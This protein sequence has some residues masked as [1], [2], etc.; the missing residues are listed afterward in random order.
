MNTKDALEIPPEVL[1]RVV[2]FHVYNVAPPEEQVLEAPRVKFAVGH[3]FKNCVIV[4]PPVDPTSYPSVN[5]I[6]LP[7]VGQFA[8]RVT[9]VAK[10]HSVLAVQIT[11]P[12]G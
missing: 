5:L 11:A 2:G 6:A 4:G 1:P 10:A 3:A 7:I 12:L 9:F 8:G